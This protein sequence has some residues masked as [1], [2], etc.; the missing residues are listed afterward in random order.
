MSTAV[1]DSGLVG[2]ILDIVTALARLGST[3]VGSTLTQIALATSAIWGGGQLLKISKVF[4]VLGNQ[5]SAFF[6]SAKTGGLISALGFNAPTILAAVAGITLLTKAADA[7]I[8]TYDE[9]KAKVDELKASY[10]ELYGAQSEYQQLADKGEAGRSNVE[11]ARFAYL[12]AQ[13]AKAEE[14]F[15]KAQEKEYKKLYGNLLTYHESYTADGIEL[16]NSASEAIAEMQDS[17]SLLNEQYY[18]D[19]TINLNQYKAGIGELTEEYGDYY[20]AIQ[21]AIDAG[22]DVDSRLMSFYNQYNELL[23]AVNSATESVTESVIE[24]SKSVMPWMQQYREAAASAFNEEQLNA[25]KSLWQEAGISASMSLS[26]MSSAL[27]VSED[28]VRA[29][30]TAWGEADNKIYMAS[31]DMQAFVDQLQTELPDGYE[32]L[33]DVATAISNITGETDPRNL[34]AYVDALK[35][36]GAIDFSD[37]ERDQL[38]EDLSGLEISVDNTEALNAID[39]VNAAMDDFNGKTVTGTVNVVTTEIGGNAKGTKNAPEGL[40]MVNEEGAEIIQSKDG[41][42]RIAGGGKPTI[43]MLHAGDKVYTAKQTAQILSNGIE[44]N[45]VGREG[46]T[47][48]F[49][50]DVTVGTIPT[51]GA[52]KS[53]GGSGGTTASAMTKDAFDEWLKER[54]HALNMDLI[55]EQEYYD[56]LEDMYKKYLD[57]GVLSQE[58]AWKY[59]EEIYKFRKKM[60]D[61]QA[62]AANSA[63]EAMAKV[64]KVWKDGKWQYVSGYGKDQAHVVSGGIGGS[65]VGAMPNTGINVGMGSIGNNAY[66]FNIDNVTLPDV[67][68]AAGFVEGLRN[69]AYQYAASRA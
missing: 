65:Y 13:R 31:D 23:N 40:S 6:G 55:T 48:S 51:V 25:F 15:R 53:S 69:Y 67:S 16:T 1:V 11:S 47:T 61:D 36:A 20:E 54:K 43:T 28:A 34:I 59:E 21:R 9:Q 42:A 38:F 18:T 24:S 26:E 57:A 30:L 32:N 5:F 7:L 66:A 64:T 19:G 22:I 27:G 46:S 68:D 45:E 3:G 62:D 50:E 58:E 56:Q 35:E 12:D 60:L 44:S 41:T 29:F 8:V 14:D 49:V 33:N 2:G 39:T 63:A 10:E 37:A 17:L 4:D 52:G